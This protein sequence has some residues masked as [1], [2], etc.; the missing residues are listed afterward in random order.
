MIDYLLIGQGI[1]GTTLAEHLLQ[2]N[3]QIRV[4]DN[5]AA[6][7]S[8]RIAAGLFTPITGIRFVK[9]WLCDQLFPYFH[10]FY[11]NMEQKL[12]QR[13]FYT[14]PSYRPFD[15]IER[16]NKWL[17]EAGEPDMSA[18]VKS[19]NPKYEGVFDEF[20]GLELN[21]SGYLDTV[22]FLDSYK[23]FLAQNDWLI[24]ETFDENK[25]EIKANSVVYG[26]IE[27]RKI[28]FCGGL[29][30]KSSRFWNFLNFRPIKGE[31]LTIKLMEGSFRS[32]LNRGVWV[33]PIGNNLYKVGS[34][35]DSNLDYEI[36]QKAL[37][38]LT[39]R[40]Q[41]LIEL[42]FEVINQQ[43]GIR[44][45]SFD[46]RPFIGLHHEYSQLGIFNGFGTKGISMSPF[47]AQE[48]SEHLVHNKKL[49]E[50]VSPNRFL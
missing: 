39:E 33:L 3:Q 36:T 6:N 10:A 16:Q 23:K 17:A 21:F 37:E 12:G 7:A 30:D 14:M 44:P 5:A 26:Q 11:A 27:A 35:Y 22:L 45:A 42:P 32:I 48:F 1:A 18:Y 2:K 15:S 40:L 31:I 8:T 43:A 47:F 20:G 34:T 24:E 19:I 41:K 13:F 28:I 4:I 46:R 50:L 38:D 9:T 29:A 49:N 25:I